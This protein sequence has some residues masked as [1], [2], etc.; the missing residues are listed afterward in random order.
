MS[1]SKKLNFINVAFNVLVGRTFIFGLNFRDA[2]F[3]TFSL[4]AWNHDLINL[5]EFEN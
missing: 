3:I 5:L 2:A 1:I 4:I